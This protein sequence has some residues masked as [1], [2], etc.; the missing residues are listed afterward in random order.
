MLAVSAPS[1]RQR[2]PQNRAST[3]KLS[4]FNVMERR[5]SNLSSNLL[6]SHGVSRASKGLDDLMPARDIIVM[7]ASAGGIETLETILSSLPWDLKASIFVVLH[8][9]EDSPGLLPEILNRS[10]K[11]P[12][13][14]AV[15]KAPILPGR[16]YV[17]P[18][19]ARHLVVDRKTVRLVPGPRENR[20][21]PSI[22]A[23]FRSA[24]V[25][26][27]A[28]V[29]GVVV[30]GNLDDGVAGLAEIKNRGG[31]ALVQEP[32]DAI[33]PSMPASAIESVRV[34]FVLPAAEIGPQLVSLVSEGVQ[35]KP[36]LVADAKSLKPTGQT[37]S[38]PEC[39]GV[40]EEIEEIEEGEPVRF[41]CR[42]GH[43][44][45]PESL[46][47][48]QNQALER[49]LWA[50]IRAL[51]EHAEFSNRL[52]SRFAKKS[53]HLARRYSKKAEISR[54]DAVVLRE[55]LDWSSDP[56][57]EREALESSDERITAVE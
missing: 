48:D 38:C 15:H 21:R 13:L 56:L 40:L 50:A 16:V 23:L 14:F 34:D 31:I 28:R 44:Y 10:T 55:L 11:V 39:D 45:S 46:H 37:Y 24:A 27:G 29:I 20:H 36:E 33:A 25:A 52:A 22:D 6:Q 47:A 41:R 54:E 35:A 51:E 53:S 5:R 1:L 19:G 4:H 57:L 18:G 2:L 7:G 3:G 12:V 8:T 17:A 26:Y 9:T 43:A 30:T 32:E 49:A 42:V